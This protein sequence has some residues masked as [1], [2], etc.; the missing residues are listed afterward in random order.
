MEGD[1]CG[2]TYH[3]WE[4]VPF[5]QNLSREKLHNDLTKPYAMCKEGIRCE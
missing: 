1:I 5:A 2:K 4:D 3:L